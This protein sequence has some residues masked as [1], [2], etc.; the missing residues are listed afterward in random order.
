MS[1]F[2]KDGQQ[3]RLR[4]TGAEARLFIVEQFGFSH[5]PDNQMLAFIDAVKSQGGN[6]VRVFGFFPFGKGH[7]E[8][9][10]VRTSTGFDL[11][12]FNETYFSYLHR[13]VDYA[14]R[15]GVVV[16]YEL[17]DS[18][19]LKFP[20]ISQYHPFGEYNHGDLGAFSEL[21]NYLLLRYQKAY[22]EKVVNLLK[23]YPNVIFG[24]MNEYAGAKEWHY[25]ISSYIKSL[26]PN[27]LLS[28]SEEG[29]PA[30]GDPNVDIWAIH[31]GSYDV[32]TC[33]P[34]V[35]H[36]VNMWQPQFGNKIVTFSTDGFGLEGIPC[37]NPTAMQ[38]LAQDVKQAGVSIFR[39]LDQDGYVGRDVAGNEYPT[40]TWF[41]QENIYETS[42]AGRLN[43]Q[44]YKAIAEVFEP[45]QFTS[46]Q[47]ATEE[48]PDGFLLA[49]NTMFL[50]APHPDAKTEK[51]GKAVPATTTQGYLCKTGAITDLPVQ[52]L[53]AAFS[54]FVDNN[55]F[56]DSLIVILDVYDVVQKK[57][58]VN[59]AVTRKQFAQGNAF[60]L[61]KLAFTPLSATSQLQLRVYYFGY[62]YVA[63]NKIAI[64]D[65]AVVT[66]T[67][68]S[69][70]PEVSWGGSPDSGDDIVPTPDEPNQGE[71]TD[72]GIIDSF[73]VANLPFQHPEAFLD[74]GARAIR[75]TTKAGFLA[76]GQYAKG[77]P[78]KPLTV[79]FNVFIDNNTADDAR[80]LSLDV[81]DSFQK[82][83]LARKEISR[84]DFAVS[85][86]WTLWDLSFTPVDESILEFRIYYHGFSYIAV[87]KIAIVD[88]DI[89][90]FANHS[91]FA[92]ALLSTSS[93]GGGSGTSTPPVVDSDALISIPQ[94][95]PDII[96]KAGG[97]NHGGQIVN[98]MYTP[99]NRG[100]IEFFRD[101]DISRGIIAEFEIEGNLANAT[102]G[103]LDGG[104]VS[105]IEFRQQGGPY[106]VS[107]Q[108]M[109]HEYEGGGRL[110]LTITDNY[111]SLEGAGFLLTIGAL[112]GDY[113][114][115]TWGDEPHRIRVILKGSTGR[116]EIDD[117]V[118]RDGWAPTDISGTKRMS[119]MLGNEFSRIDH[120]HAITR[121]KNFTL[122]YI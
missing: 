75:A 28:G 91:Q 79:Y 86:A 35:Q 94:F 82:K 20:Q 17:F 3:L 41:N 85:G 102:L 8:E 24:V 66:L 55:V 16:L 74:K 2:Q 112:A 77:Y 36:D 67:T 87:E 108:R 40:G 115:M 100:G 78:A 19:G 32:K 23:N 37:G 95:T 121:F 63:V 111:G 61:M 52:P 113:T 105:F 99:S 39:Y 60:N 122:R 106:Y 10:F 57:V 31:T 44:V 13:W 5:Y 107:F 54:V 29:S 48:L 71:T 34:N 50:D 110:R 12:Q 47:P 72:S 26:A 104:K 76:Y 93:S 88:P 83:I 73:D 4:D 6:G 120:Q 68:P 70:I 9:P 64:V 46:G 117:F 65:P 1:W 89:V 119:I 118:S 18:V 38:V 59:W 7:E 25:E 84:R 103:E 98:G 80:I 96:S 22:V 33:R 69:D 92:M 11:D 14:Y 62:A 116:I 45:T 90:R 43:T 27:H 30:M 21:T 56:D 97:T 81:Y 15:Q 109:L 49:L 101:I 42:Q 53:E 114:T 51:G 58:V